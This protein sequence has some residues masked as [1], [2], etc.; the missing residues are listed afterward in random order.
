M[1][2]RMAT[3]PV[4]LG[5]VEWHTHKKKS[6]QDYKSVF[7]RFRHEIKISLRC[8]TSSL[9]GEILEFSK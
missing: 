3:D 1:V 4:Y 2:L 7:A 6:N 8:L 9:E 5:S